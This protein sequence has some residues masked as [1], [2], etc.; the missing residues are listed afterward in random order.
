[1]KRFI[2][3]PIFALL[4]GCLPQESPKQIVV[5]G[6]AEIEVA[7]DSFRMNAII[8][9]RAGDKNAAI[10]EISSTLDR[11]TTQLPS[12]EGLGSV[13]VEPSKVEIQPIFD[14]EC[15]ENRY[16]DETCPVTGQ[17]AEIFVD[18]EG[19]PAAVAGNAFSLLSEFGADEVEFE[20]YFL[21]N[22][23]SAESKADKQAFDDARQKAQRLAD[24]AN[25][26]LLRPVRISS[27]QE[28]F[29]RNLGLFSDQDTVVVTGARIQPKNILSIAPPPITIEREVSVTFEIE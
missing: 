11:I 6:D 24:A 29:A 22:P 20:E 1:M 15:S 2:V 21:S 14:E 25:V 8:R 23:A 28:R 13:K 17:F 16:D 19:A 9:S 3:I 5:V 18:I 10:Q 26:T 7:A 4:A 12:L 27:N